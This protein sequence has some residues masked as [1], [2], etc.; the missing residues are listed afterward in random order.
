MKI[1]PAW[2]CSSPH[3]QIMGLTS[4]GDERQL[5]PCYLRF[6]LSALAHVATM[7]LADS[8]VS[9]AAHQDVTHFYNRRSLPQKEVRGSFEQTVAT[10]GRLT[11]NRKS[12][13]LL[14]IS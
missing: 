4:L 9:L 7:Q 1:A 11:R 8:C 12:E 6:C 2:R 14:H 5:R 10:H 3:R 13:V